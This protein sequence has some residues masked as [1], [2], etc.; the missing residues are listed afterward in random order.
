MPRLAPVIAIV[1]AALVATPMSVLGQ[2][3]V[4]RGEPTRPSGAV[5]S[6]AYFPQD[7][8]EVVDPDK[9][10]AAG[11]EITVEIE[12]DREGGFPKVVSATGEIDVQPVGRV[13]VAGKTTVEAQADIKRL[14]EKDY[15]YTATVKVS[16]DRRSRT[17][18]KAGQITLSGEVR[19]VGPMDLMEGEKLTVSQAILKA[20][21]FG[22]FA[23]Q[24]KV[25]V[26]RSE[27]G[28]T[29]QFYVDVKEILDKGAVGK[30][31]T[32]QDGDRINVPRAMIK[33]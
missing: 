3:A 7:R 1:A 11:D 14:L 22:A 31:V 30:D 16:I 19:G 23:N 25:Q 13:K 21:G 4:P 8:M 28:G 26:T 32:V 12:Q 15:Y 29:R 24:R 2:G 10:L 20:G 27:S 5:T 6:P 9:R 18:V 17:V 33:F